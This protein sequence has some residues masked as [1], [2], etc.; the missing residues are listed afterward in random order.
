MFGYLRNFNYT[1]H[2]CQIQKTQNLK[3]VKLHLNDDDELLRL[4]CK[5]SKNTQTIKQS[6][7]DK[8]SHVQWG[9]VDNDREN[10]CFG[11]PEL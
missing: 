3:N 11:R 8:K 9:L 4:D 5:C 2:F 6:R 10:R 1:T 7:M